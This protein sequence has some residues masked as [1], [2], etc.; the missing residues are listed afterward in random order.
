MRQCL[1]GLALV[2]LAF[3]AC[4]PA[5]ARQEPVKDNVRLGTRVIEG[6]ATPGYLWLRDDKGVVM[7]YDRATG[8][9]RPLAASG[10]QDMSLNNDVLAALVP[11][12]RPGAVLVT[13]LLSGAHLTAPLELTTPS[14][15]VLLLSDNQ[16]MVLSADELAIWKDGAWVIKSLLGRLTFAPQTDALAVGGRIYLGYNRGEWGGGLQAVDIETGRIDDIRRIDGETCKGPLG[17]ECDPV[18][19]LVSDRSSDCLLA[20][21]GLSHFLAHGRILRV[22]G[23]KVEVVY[24]QAGPL[25]ADALGAGISTW[26]FFGLTSSAEGWS[27]VS[28]GKLFRGQWDGSVVSETLPELAPWSDLRV[29]FAGPDIILVRTDVNWGMSLSGFTP[30]LV[31]VSQ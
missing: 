12:Q 19:G 20:S 28:A 27:A 5:N 21:V 10:V 30:L 15:G 8:N 16:T 13:D 23:A 17:A 31:S 18:T 4:A 11:A 25:P 26:P 24:S 22:C 2:V 7:E 9:R 6:A 29:A 3:S 1:F 14:R